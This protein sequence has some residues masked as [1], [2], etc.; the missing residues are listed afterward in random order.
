MRDSQNIKETLAR[1]ENVSKCYGKL[2]A[3]DSLSLSVNAGEML[4]LLG[5]NGAGKTT[6]VSLLLNLIEADSGRVSLFDQNPKE[7]SARQRIGVMLQSAELPETLRV[8]EL[9]ALTQSY[10]QKKRAV[11]EICEMAGVADLLPRFYGKLSGGQQRRV[12]FA[13]AICAK[14]DILFLDEPTVGL[15]IEAREAMWQCLR[16]LVAE[17]CAIVLTT[18]YLEEAEAL[19]DRVMVIAHGSVIAEGSVE[20]IRSRV[21]LR[22]IRCVSQ[23]EI[24]KIK[25]WP[26]IESASHDGQYLMIQTQDAELVTRR[27]L[28][29]DETLQQLEIKRAGLAE[30]FLELTREQVK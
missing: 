14:V 27:L 2:R 8:S 29:E 1:L 5:P 24:E 26:G 17:G 11:A 20:S 21:S 3:L 9:I 16:K 23:I 15:D 4:A 25:Q 13:L 7:L 30:A 19:A 22:R 12:Q 18:H 28:N 6:A 10:Y